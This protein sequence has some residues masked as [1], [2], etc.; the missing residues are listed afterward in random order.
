MSETTADLCAADGGNGKRRRYSS[1]TAGFWQPKVFNK[2]SRRR[3]ALARRRALAAHLGRPPSYPEQI[4]ISRLIALEWWLRRLDARID[5]GEELSGH[6]IRGRLAAENRLR[7]DL[8]A[9]GLA[10]AEARPMTPAEAL[11]A[12]RAACQPRVPDDAE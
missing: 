5:D 12:A 1:S 10:P 6:A 2:E 11:A 9:L 8:Q 4:I 7:L 3:F